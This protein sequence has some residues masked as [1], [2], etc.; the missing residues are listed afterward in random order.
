MFIATPFLSR[1]F[2]NK[3]HTLT[4]KKRGKTDSE[5]YYIYNKHISQNHYK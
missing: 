4:E 2:I 1:M 3:Q 5:R